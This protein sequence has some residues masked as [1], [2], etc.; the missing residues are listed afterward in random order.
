MGEECRHAKPP[1]RTHANWIKAAAA[2]EQHVRG[3]HEKE[4]GLNNRSQPP[5]LKD[6]PCEETGIVKISPMTQIPLMDIVWDVVPDMMHITSGVWDR[7]I[8]GLMRGSV[9]VSKPDAR[10]SWTT[11]NNA[12][13]Q[14][15]YEHAAQDVGS[16]ALVSVF[17]VFT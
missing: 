6:S 17:L 1:D 15:N 12:E 9:K 4:G 2:N 16:W 8:F 13:L 14:Q 10:K 7:H 5:F 11:A 3:C